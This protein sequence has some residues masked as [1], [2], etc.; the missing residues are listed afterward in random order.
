MN[1]RS[2]TSPHDRRHGAH[3]LAAAALLV[4]LAA[5]ACS[6]GSA[7][8]ASAP[9]SP[10]PASPP[11]VAPSVAPVS[12]APSGDEPLE[13]VP[14]AVIDAAI[15]DAAGRAGVEPSAVEIVSTSSRDWP[16]GALGCPEPGMMYTDVITP[17][18]R[19]V[20][21]AGGTRYDYRA[22]TRSSDVRWCENPPG[23]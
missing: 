5:G 21:E 2:A 19:V 20:V 13:G 3:R 23:P 14:Q 16:N 8:S 6:G 12:G 17:G 9:A 10:E 15:A 4:G 1:D 11:V 22:S 7:A 18:Y